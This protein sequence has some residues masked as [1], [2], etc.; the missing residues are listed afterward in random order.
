MFCATTHSQPVYRPFWEIFVIN[1]EQFWAGDPQVHAGDLISAWVAAPDGSPKPGEWYF[2][3]ADF[4]SG[5]TWGEYYKLPTSYNKDTFKTV[6]AVTEWSKGY[7]CATGSAGNTCRE[8]DGKKGA[9]RKGFAYLG[10]VNYIDAYWQTDGEN[11][12]PIAKSRISMYPDVPRIAAV[13]ATNPTT[14]DGSDVPG[15]AFSTNY[16]RFWYTDF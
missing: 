5:K 13:T 16:T 2:E 11:L 7:Y 12:L 14:S 1:N 9:I 6:E 10:Q 4:T 8:T 3:V 15:D